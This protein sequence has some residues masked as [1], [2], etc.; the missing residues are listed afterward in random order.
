ERERLR[1]YAE[2]WKAGKDPADLERLRDLV[3]KAGQNPH[4]PPDG[5]DALRRTLPAEPGPMPPVIQPPPLNPGV[6]PVGPEQPPPNPTPAPAPP[7][8]AVPVDESTA[9]WVD[10]L[11]DLLDGLDPDGE[12]VGT[13]IDW[14]HGLADDDDPNPST[15]KTVIRGTLD[16]IF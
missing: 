4:L 11:T 10:G 3:N 2:R 13:M 12:W 8:S 9:G 7:P 16:W 14:L 6:G 5:L 1:Q 15:T